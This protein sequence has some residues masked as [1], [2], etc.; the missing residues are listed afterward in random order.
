MK[1]IIKVKIDK[2][3]NKGKTGMSRI[4][5]TIILCYTAVTY[6]PF[7]GNSTVNHYH[8]YH[9][10]NDTHAP[11]EVEDAVEIQEETP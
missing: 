9:H 6:Y 2:I 7:D 11:V 8:Y 5:C 3:I 1:S 4:V 10:G